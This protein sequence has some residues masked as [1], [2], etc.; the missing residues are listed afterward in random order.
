[1]IEFTI[2]SGPDS[3]RQFSIQK[4]QI[5]VGRAPHTDVTI[6]NDKAVSAHHAYVVR[7]D[8][9]WLLVDRSKNGTFVRQPDGAF[10]RVQGQY[11]LGSKET[12]RVGRTTLHIDCA[13]SLEQRSAAGPSVEQDDQ[14]PPQEP[15][16][17]SIDIEG[18]ALKHHLLSSSA[19]GSRYTAAYCESDLAEINARLRRVAAEAQLAHGSRP[20]NQ[21]Q[22]SQGHCGA[23]VYDHLFP[24][25]IRQNLAGLAN[26]DL[27]LLHHAALADV[28]W[29]IAFGDGDFLCLRFNL[30]RQMLVEGYSTAMMPR[31]RPTSL[32]VLIVSDPTGDMPEAHQGAEEIFRLVRRVGPQY[33]VEFLAGARIE[34]TDLLCRLKRADLVYYAGHAEYVECD[35]SESGWRLKNGCVTCNDFHKLD[36]PPLFV[37]ANGCQTARE[38]PIA[39]IE[40]RWG[41]GMASAFILCG[42][43]SYLGT[44]WP[45][46]A[47]GSAAFAA[48][49]FRNLLTGHSI[50]VSV[51]QARQRL[52]EQAGLTETVWASYVLYGDPS[53]RFV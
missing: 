46:P 52:I 30:G 19:R 24:A 44:L 10:V 17:L 20:P 47:A 43:E 13:P 5:T 22:E 31:R 7:Q 26:Q 23:F 36:P 8:T 15:V 38:A 48:A 51:R 21:I 42:V 40:T 50:G 3:G 35:P 16:V 32:R 53:R 2:I 6:P 34:R 9:E 12:V 37:F 29:E 1:M 45:I 11:R 49:F 33:R 28:P 18:P 14:P 39:D 4:E 41:G 25:H 27:F